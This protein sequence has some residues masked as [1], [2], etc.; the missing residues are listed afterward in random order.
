[1]EDVWHCCG[2][3]ALRVRLCHSVFDTGF[4]VL[5]DVLR[6]LHSKIINICSPF[7]QNSPPK[8]VDKHFLS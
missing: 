4:T 5:I 3:W 7:C 6:W 2:F 8:V 1:M